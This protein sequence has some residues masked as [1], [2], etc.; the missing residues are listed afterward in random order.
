MDFFFRS[1]QENET[2]DRE[3]ERDPTPSSP[4][5]QSSQPSSHVD[6]NHDKNVLVSPCEGQLQPELEPEHP[7]SVRIS[8]H[9]NSNSQSDIVD[10]HQLVQHDS[11]PSTPASV[12]ALRKDLE[13][14]KN[15]ASYNPARIPTGSTD[16][17]SSIL[18][19]EPAA[20]I[21]ANC[22]NVNVNF[23]G[24]PSHPVACGSNE[25]PFTPP[26]RI[27]PSDCL[28]PPLTPDMAATIHTV[29]QKLKKG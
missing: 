19:H 22:R 27:M 21:M 29:E 4:D 14:L 15:S 2:H 26:R 16:A 20:N 8:E 6:V 17:P 11:A 24:L 1:K 5:T 7:K 3:L 28:Q 23:A 18:T 10:G 25:A 12:A 13:N 9:S